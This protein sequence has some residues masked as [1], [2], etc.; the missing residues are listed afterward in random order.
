MKT[1]ARFDNAIQKLYEAFH[2]DS[3]NP[4]CC[5]QCAVGN[6]LDNND[7]WKD[8][9]TG[10]GSTELSYVGKVNEVFGKRFAGFTPSELLQIESVF[11][12]SCG[13]ILP[14]TSSLKKSEFSKEQLFDGLV[15]TVELLCKIE[16]I[17]NVL[18]CSELF[19]FKD[20]EF[21]VSET[22]E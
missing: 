9:S 11:L 2:S 8:L 20:Q 17:P 18:D 3:L 14:V 4:L 1:S 12:K 22:S 21:L 15:A 6:I 7:F 19:D 13:V 5:K 16:G 10:H